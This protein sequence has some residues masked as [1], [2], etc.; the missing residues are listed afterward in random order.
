MEYVQPFVISEVALN[1]SQQVVLL[2]VEDDRAMRSLLCDELW[3]LGVRIVEAADGDEAV[4]KL[5]DSQPDLILTDLRMP[6]GGL[7]YVA[8]LRTLAPS[9]PIVLMTAFGDART[10]EE[11]RRSGV[12]AYFDKPVRMA[13]L[14]ATIRQLLSNPKGASASQADKHMS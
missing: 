5:A 8:R 4:Q 13:D 11:A 2:V 12:A 7:D 1:E 10:R 6:A 9:C 14:K 3:D